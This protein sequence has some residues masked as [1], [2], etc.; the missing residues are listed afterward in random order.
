MKVQITSQPRLNRRQ[1]IMIQAKEVYL[2]DDIPCQVKGCAFCTHE[3]EQ[4]LENT[5]YIMDNEVLE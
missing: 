2:S 1:Q 5:V 4:L 3:C